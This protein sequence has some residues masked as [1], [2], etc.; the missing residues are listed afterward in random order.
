MRLSL[1]LSPM[2][3]GEARHPMTAESSHR[4]LTCSSCHSAHRYDTVT[5]AV[6]SCV[7][8]HD[9]Q[10]S[11]E[12]AGSPHYQLWLAEVSGEALAGSGVSCA[13]CHM[14]RI[15]D[16]DVKVSHNQ[17]ANL[18]PRE[19]MVR[20]VCLECHGLQFSLDALADPALKE[21]CYSTLPA[22][23]VESL[24]MTRT[25]FGRKAATRAS[26][27]SVKQGTP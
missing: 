20:S 11:R 18:R 13:S 21:N 14:P 2:T 12:Y 26:R 5:A 7:S 1:G 6:S 10:H 25:W 17:N 27:Q 15:D 3:P 4:S 19:K 8:C 22:A 16:G 9:D 23:R 24:E